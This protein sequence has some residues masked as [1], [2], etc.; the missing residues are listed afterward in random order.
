MIIDWYHKFIPRKTKPFRK[1]PSLECLAYY[2]QS[3]NV[4]D[5]QFKSVAELPPRK[6]L[7][8]H[9]SVQ[10]EISYFHHR[11]RSMMKTSDKQAPYA[12]CVMDKIMSNEK[13][14]LVQLHSQFVIDKEVGLNFWDY[15]SIYK[16]VRSM[17]IRAS[18]IFRA[19]LIDCHKSDCSKCGGS[20]YIYI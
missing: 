4:N 10:A 1:R 2:L 15:Y 18:E 13:F 7:F 9:F 14:E 19:A 17:Q 8:C 6:R 16:K 20:K 12:D 5:E 3:K 11:L